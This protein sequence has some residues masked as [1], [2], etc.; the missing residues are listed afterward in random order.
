MQP[1]CSWDHAALRGSMCATVQQHATMQKLCM[2]A[3]A[4]QGHM[5]VALAV[6]S[7][8][9]AANA[10]LGYP[11]SN[12]KRVIVVQGSQGTLPQGGNGRR[13]LTATQ[14]WLP[15]VTAGR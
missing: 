7:M 5:R 12:E 3:G 1:Q 6:N 11:F 2:H 8:E 13:L 9:E 15:F 4:M 10:R 14:L